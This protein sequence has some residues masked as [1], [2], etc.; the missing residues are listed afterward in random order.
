[1]TF[2]STCEDAERSLDTSLLCPRFSGKAPKA[3]ERR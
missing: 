1:M 3:F 2:Y